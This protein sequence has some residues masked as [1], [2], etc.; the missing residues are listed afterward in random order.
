MRGIP[1]WAAAFPKPIFAATDRFRIQVYNA[2]SVL[3]HQ[4]DGLL[5]DGDIRFGG[6]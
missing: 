6:N 1:H 4:A 2:R 5:L 3:I